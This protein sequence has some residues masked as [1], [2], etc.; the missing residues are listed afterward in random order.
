MQQF[1]YACLFFMF[2]MKLR[3]L[4]YGLVL[5]SFVMLL[6]GVDNAGG[7]ASHLGGAVAGWYLIRNSHHLHGFF[8][9]LGRVDPSSHHYREKRGARSLQSEADRVLDRMRES[10]KGFDGLSERDRA[11]LRRARR[12]SGTS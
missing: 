10:G 3:T 12:E 6:W 8:D 2:P 11:T 7:E 4:A 9:V 1:F 5:V